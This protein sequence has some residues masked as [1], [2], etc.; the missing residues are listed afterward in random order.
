MEKYQKFELSDLVSSPNL[1]GTKVEVSAVVKGVQVRNM[2]FGTRTGYTAFLKDGEALLLIQ[3]NCDG[4]IKPLRELSMLKT[5]SET[6]QPISV[7]GRMKG[8]HMKG[9]RS[10]Y[11]LKVFGVKLGD[12][13]SVRY[14]D[15]E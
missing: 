14:E 13:A 8:T 7:Q 15:E 12:Y 4:G 5:S 11:R 6:G 9:S 1:K 10:L 3:G 2:C